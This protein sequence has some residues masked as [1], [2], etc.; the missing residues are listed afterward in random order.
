MKPIALRQ[1]VPAAAGAT[2]EPLYWRRHQVMLGLIAVLAAIDIVW[3]AFFTDLRIG[4]AG[5]ALRLGIAAA[6]GLAAAY[7]GVSGRS[8]RL[9]ATLLCVA[10]LMGLEI[11]ATVFN[12]LAIRIGF[13]LADADFARWSDVF[14]LRWL[15]Y[16]A[17]VMDRPWLAISLHILYLSSVVQILL[18]VLVLGFTGRLATLL[19]FVVVLSVTSVVTVI[20][21]AM[22]PGVGAHHFYGIPDHGAASFV[23]AILGSHD[24]TLLF[25]DMDK[26]EGLV[27]FP[28]YHTVIS[29]ALIVAFWPIRILRYAGLAAN[30]ALIAGVPVWGSH[31]FIDVVSGFAVWLAAWLL[32]RRH[33]PRLD[34]IGA[35]G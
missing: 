31:Y 32:W 10:E 17:F 21:G 29:L 14:G 23:P 30:A 16:N 27:V 2:E 33:A 8:T 12:Y 24:G 26:V 9:C 25:L 5:V 1:A 22:M 6:V 13:P 18:A 20:V 35:R 19:E 15:D 28:S 34:G 11:F 4:L 3:L 7:Y